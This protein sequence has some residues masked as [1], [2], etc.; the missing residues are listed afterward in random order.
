[1]D[2]IIILIIV[3][4]LILL[5]IFLGVKFGSKGIPSSA[6]QQGYKNALITLVIMAAIFGLLWSVI[7]FGFKQSSGSSLVFSGVII[8]VAIYVW[9]IISWLRNR[10]IAGKILL[11]LIS[12]PNKTLALIMGVLFIILGFSGTYSFMWRD[13]EYSWFIS[14][15]I[16]LSLG[17]YQ[18]FMSFSHIRVHERGIM[19]Y[20]DLVKWEKIESFEWRSGNQQAYTLKLK[21]KGRLP[22]FMREGALPAVCQILCKVAEPSRQRVSLAF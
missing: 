11:D 14:S 19:A 8:W 12:Y 1:M 17:I 2:T 22:G 9:V 21:Y 6:M 3:G 4:A 20:V 5:G 10:N 16:G 15:L 18:I 7:F 13:F